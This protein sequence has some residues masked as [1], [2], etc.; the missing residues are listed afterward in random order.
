MKKILLVLTVSLFAFGASYAGNT[1]CGL[2]TMIIG[3]KDSSLLQS[4]AVTTN[5]TS[6]NQTFGI[7]SGTLG[8]KKPSKFAQS[9]RVNTFVMANMDNL[10][11]DIARGQGETLSNLAAMMNVSDVDKFGKNLQTKFDTIYASADVE[12]ADVVDAIYASI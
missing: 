2:G 7:S 8:C 6:A 1:G 5:G 11:V 12:Y 10:A 9:E 4:L 3:E